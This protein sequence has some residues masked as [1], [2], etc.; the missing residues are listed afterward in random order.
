LW[1]YYLLGPHR[2]WRDKRVEFKSIKDFFKDLKRKG[3]SDL[4]EKFDEIAKTNTHNI[5]FDTWAKRWNRNMVLLTIKE[6][7]KNNLSVNARDIQKEFHGLYKAAI[8]YFK[9]WPLALEAADI[10]YDD[11]KYFKEWSP[12]LVKM[13]ILRL[14]NAGED[15]SHTGIHKKY[16]TLLWAA[17]RYFDKWSKA[18]E[19]CNINYSQF[20]RQEK[21]T[22]ERVL[23][24]LKQFV[25]KGI[26]LTYTGMERNH[27][28]LLVA[29]ERYFETWQE[30]LNF[31]GLDYKTIRL[32]KKWTPDLVIEEI[33]DLIN[34]KEILKSSYVERHYR[35]LFKAA[36][37]Y[38]NSWNIAVKTAASRE[39]CQNG[40]NLF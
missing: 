7:Y 21:W 32:Q 31:L 11:I 38:F 9:S 16:P 36:G 33:V 15:L 34:R 40:A 37:R 27:P 26:D 8:R 25:R 2:K 1:I 30:A 14:Y 20:L 23:E 10:N 19:N 29:A 6:R 35:P 13:E 22:R 17:I 24:E 28:K 18:V 12:E 39:K 5:V 4:I 3:R